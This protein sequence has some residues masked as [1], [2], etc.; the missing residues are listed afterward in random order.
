VIGKAS[1]ATNLWP[2][3]IAILV[4]MF[5]DCVRLRVAPS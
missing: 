2:K 3:L 5:S 4:F 1:I